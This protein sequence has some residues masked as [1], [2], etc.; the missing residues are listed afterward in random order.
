MKENKKEKKSEFTQ[1]SVVFQI[2][3][4]G[5]TKNLIEDLEY[6][7]KR[8]RIVKVKILKNSPYNSREEAFEV[9]EQSLPPKAKITEKKG[10]I[11]LIN[12]NKID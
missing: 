8:K 5:I 10:W 9:L 2:G 11:A 1:E 12:S 6:Q 7:L 4:K 3:K